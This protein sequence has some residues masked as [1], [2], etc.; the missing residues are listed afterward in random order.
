RLL[1]QAR[2]RRLDD[3]QTATWLGGSFDGANVASGI[4]SAEETNGMSLSREMHKHSKDALKIAPARGKLGVLLPGL[5]AV[6]TTFIAGCLLAR[7]GIAEP[8]GS[9]TQ[10]GTIRLG[11]RTDR[12]TPFVRDFVPIATL[13]DLVFGAW[14]IF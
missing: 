10:L 8:V 3:E 2:E 1:A 4:A 5:G 7:R 9:V 13:P 11:K 6:A 14:D 12:R